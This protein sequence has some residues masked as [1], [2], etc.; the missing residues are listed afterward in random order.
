MSLTPTEIEATKQEYRQN[1]KLAGLSR[2]E[3]SADLGVS[4]EKLER[5]LNLHQRSLEDA[6]ILRN[7]LL[8]KVE[9]AGEKPVPFTALKGDPA[10]H[11]FLDADTIHHGKMTPGDESR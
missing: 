2:Q 6:W 1:M 7:Y 5:I 10:D 8:T 11:W 3:I 9:E 4:E